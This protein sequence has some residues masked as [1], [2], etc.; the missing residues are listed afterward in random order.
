MVSVHHLGAAE[1][2][3][4][5]S[6][7]DPR[8]KVRWVLSLPSLPHLFFFPFAHFF[9]QSFNYWLY[10]LSTYS[11][12]GPDI[13]IFLVTT[14]LSTDFQISWEILYQSFYKLDFP[15]SPRWL[16]GTVRRIEAGRLWGFC[17]M[18]CP[19]CTG[20]SDSFSVTEILGGGESRYKV[21]GFSICKGL[22]LYLTE[23]LALVF[24]F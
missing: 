4:N 16:V 12:S 10:I 3:G 14:E 15:S 8:K 11:L 9:M 17:S 5:N 24:V 21:G 18:L 23:R 2:N 13:F 22:L 7:K 20:F 19:L 6:Q 1:K